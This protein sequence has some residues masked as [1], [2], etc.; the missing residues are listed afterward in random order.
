[1][2]NYIVLAKSNGHAELISGT[3]I[4]LYE[5][6]TEA[7]EEAEKIVR[8]YPQKQIYVA[9]LTHVVRH[10]EDPVEVVPL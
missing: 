10:V 2:A 6:E 1:M 3:V 9:E 8:Q 7:L 5:S 4:K